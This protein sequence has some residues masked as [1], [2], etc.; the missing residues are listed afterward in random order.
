MDFVVVHVSFAIICSCLN[1]LYSPFK[2]K[3]T[4]VAL[5]PTRLTINSLERCDLPQP[6]LPVMMFNVPSKAVAS[7]VKSEESLVPP[8]IMGSFPSI[9]A[10]FISMG[11]DKFFDGGL[12]TAGKPT[13]AW[14][15]HF[16]FQ[17]CP[18]LA[19]QQDWRLEC[20]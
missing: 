7:I 3:M 15:Q 12:G 16:I 11:M 6:F 14:A 1:L 10:N 20:R 17:R 8:K 19:N 2:S 18:Y 9:F 5:Y 13:A 4:T